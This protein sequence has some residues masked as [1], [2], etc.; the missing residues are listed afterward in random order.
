VTRSELGSPQ[1]GVVSPVLANIFLHEVLDVWFHR[2]VRSR[3]QGRA[4][5]VRYADDAVMLFEY[6]EDARRV[7]AVLPQRLG[8]Y[9]LTL[10]LDKTRLVAFKWPD[11]MGYRR[12]DDGPGGPRRAPSSRRGRRVRWKCSS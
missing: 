6:E 2:E 8:K 12:N 9:G 10:H 4:H 5:L 1:G 11:R 3:L 7:T